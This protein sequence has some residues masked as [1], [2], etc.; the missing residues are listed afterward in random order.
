MTRNVTLL[1]EILDS[2]T[3]LKVIKEQ[4]DDLNLWLDDVKNIKEMLVKV[5][6]VTSSTKVPIALDSLFRDTFK[7][8]ICAVVPIEPPIIASKCCKSILGCQSCVDTWFSGENAC[9]KTCPKCRTE[10]GYA[11]T[12]RLNGFD[13]LLK[14]LKKIMSSDTD[15]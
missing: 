12:M 3:D 10:R 14:E 1:E 13:E 2:L 15:E 11:E 7:C 4:V 5:L 9:S 8:T 6:S